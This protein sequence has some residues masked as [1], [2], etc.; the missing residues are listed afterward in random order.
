MMYAYGKFKSSYDAFGLV[1][2]FIP[3]DFGVFYVEQLATMKTQVENFWYSS[4]G[5]VAEN[6]G[7]HY[8]R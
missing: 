6:Y 4:D 7:G 5:Y 8:G 1:T 3:S 2:G